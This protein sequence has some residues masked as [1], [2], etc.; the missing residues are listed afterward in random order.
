MTEIGQ[1]A[2][3]RSTGQT[4]TTTTASTTEE[5][6]DFKVVVTLDNPPLGL[7][8]GLSTTAK[9]T[10]ATRQNVV[11]IPIQALTIR[12]RR[13]L[14]ESDKKANGKALAAEKQAGAAPPSAKEL[15]KAKE[16][17]QGVF[18]IRNGRATFVPVE[19]GIMG[20]TNVEIVKGL[21]PGDQIVT[22]S[23]QVLRTL[24]NNTKVKIE[25]TPPAGG[26]PMPS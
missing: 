18:V 23:F 8:P 5:A 9:I 12:T 16:E 11:N 13:E 1:A 19:S 17:V 6:K 2:V 14:E 15:E 7:R 22:G 10:T 3:S 4:T 25:K 26:G 21:Q 20:A 24:K